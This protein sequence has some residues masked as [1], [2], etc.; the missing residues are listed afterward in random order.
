MNNSIETNFAEATQTPSHSTVNSKPKNLDELADWVCDAIDDV[1]G[2]DITVLDVSEKSSI[3]ELMIIATGT[4]SRHISSMADQLTLKAKQANIDTYCCAG[5]DAA[6]WV[7]IDLGDV[8]VHLMQQE[9]RD[10]Y[11]LEKLWS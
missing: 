3:T 1:K 5:K 8:I 6:D 7:V 2:Q 4:S 9:A 11:A 10:L